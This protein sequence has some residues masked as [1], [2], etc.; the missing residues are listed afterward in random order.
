MKKYAMMIMGNYEPETDT[1]EITR[2]GML[3]RYVTVRSMEEA[4]TTAR[5]LCE[6]G[7]GC[8]ELCGAFGKEGAR[9]MIQETNGEMA[10]G[11]CVNDPDMDQKI[12]E[13][14]S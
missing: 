13:F 8:L 14:F 2:G 10:V 1:L 4:V 12:Q 6:E 9:R 5:K 3:T 11:Y 7:F